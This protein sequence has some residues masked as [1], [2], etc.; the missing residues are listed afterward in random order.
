MPDEDYP[1]QHQ[2]FG[3]PSEVDQKDSE[4]P[5]EGS[6]DAPKVSD[7][8][9]GYETKSSEKTE[10]HTLSVRQTAKI[11]EQNR[12]PITERTILNR[13][14][15]NKRGEIRLDCYFGEV[16]AKYYITPQSVQEDIQK[17]RSKVTT[18]T[19]GGI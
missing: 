10:H 6:E 7:E 12:I 11:F 15:P 1:T 16:E 17:E 18:R 8:R 19:S 3:M 13:C 4:T 2:D 5:L 14:H 9:I